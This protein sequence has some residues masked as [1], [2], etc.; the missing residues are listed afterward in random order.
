[1]N[2]KK[3]KRNRRYLCMLS[4]SLLRDCYLNYTLIYHLPVDELR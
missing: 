4:N 1:M 2:K 3:Y